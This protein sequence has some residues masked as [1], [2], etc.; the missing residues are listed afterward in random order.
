[1]TSTSEVLTFTSNDIGGNPAEGNELTAV[2][3]TAVPEPAAWALMLAGFG[4][5]GGALRMSRRR[6]GVISPV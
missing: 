5:L 1:A 2:S 4:G 3:L 6:T